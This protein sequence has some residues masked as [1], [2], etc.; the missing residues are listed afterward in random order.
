MPEKLFCLSN[1]SLCIVASLYT[2]SLAADKA[3][4]DDLKSSPQPVLS[5]S[6]LDGLQT[7]D[8]TPWR[9]GRFKLQDSWLTAE[10]LS[11]KH[12]DTEYEQ[13]REAQSVGSDSD[14][15]L[16][17]W[18]NLNH[19]TDRARA[20]YFNFLLTNPNHLEARQN[21][22][23]VLVDGNWVDRDSLDVARRSF[24]EQLNDL[25]EWTP[26]LRG[27]LSEIK[28]GNTK[29]MAAALKRLDNMDA[30]AALPAL[31]LFAANVDKDLA[32]PLIGRIE[33]IKSQ[34][35][36]MALARVALAHPDPSVQQTAAQ[37]IKQYPEHFYVPE[38][39]GYLQTDMQV[40]KKLV[41]YPDGNI[42]LETVVSG[43]LRDRKLQHRAHQVISIIA[44]FSSSSR[45]TL[46]QKV[47]AEIDIWSLYYNIP[48]SSPEYFSDFALAVEN[49]SK[50]GFSIDGYVPRNVA[51]VTARN[52]EEQGKQLERSVARQNRMHMERTNRV[53]S[54]LRTTTGQDLGDDSLQWWAW[55]N[56]HSE[57]YEDRKQT[58][59][60]YE[61]RSARYRVAATHESSNATY[62]AG[63]DFGETTMQYSCLVPGTL[64]QTETG[65]RPI[66]QIRTGDRVLSQNV[67]TGEIGL[68]AVM[69]TTV[70]PPKETIVIGTSGE[71]IQAT[72]GHYWWV[73]GKGW[74]RSR[75]LEP[76]MQLQRAGG[77]AQVTSIE[78]DPVDQPTHNLIVDHFNTYF[79]GKQRILSY[80]NSLLKPT[81]QTTIG[82][83]SLKSVKK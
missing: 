39:L 33:L 24:Q 15:A 56:S 75:D 28:S 32:K 19:R 21:L 5:D 18:C 74:L 1:L 4:K 31:A 17:R 71:T 83:V 40:A 37:A 59:I 68:Q 16:A 65:L 29:R 81:L 43:E 51:V 58:A 22:K 35:A 78:L 14:L 52:L 60:T 45:M 25:E 11:E 63:H 79:V 49:N 55:W 47:S 64:I 69:T 57:R 44:S 70:R 46:K 6:T 67:Q 73:V 2:Q 10:E 27:I 20:H 42:T 72:G 48:Q 66:E 12:K 41:M 61:N 30:E 9:D 26:V 7:D 53:C 38:L 77:T 62:Q 80:D 34:D 23:H 76:G 3:S 82:S 8:S 36:C 13:V 54:L 50:N